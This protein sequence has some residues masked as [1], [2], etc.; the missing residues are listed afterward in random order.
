MTID[1]SAGRFGSVGLTAQDVQGIRQATDRDHIGSIFSRVWDK[2]ADWFCSTNRTEAKKC[3]FDLHSQTTTHQQKVDSFLS[4]KDM[5]GANYQNRFQIEE[6]DEGVRY[7]LDLS[8][9][10]CPGFSL[11]FR[12][13]PVN[14][15]TLRQEL[16]RSDYWSHNGVGP[17]RD[18]VKADICRASYTVSGTPLPDGTPDERMKHFDDALTAIG[19]TPSQ[20]EAI[21]EVCNQAVLG[22]FMEASD[23]PAI[24]PGGQN[25]RYDVRMV[26]GEVHVRAVCIKDIDMVEPGRQVD[27][28][29]RQGKLNMILSDGDHPFYK[30]QEM[31]LDLRIMDGDPRAMIDIAGVRHLA[32][33]DVDTVQVQ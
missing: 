15:E 17:A 20:R 5:A 3:M 12:K 9:E 14:Q 27:L 33:R 24:V 30:S 13:L 4:L 6:N 29:Q 8:D 32:S 28:E 18:Q 2:V 21:M 11:S 19:A 31:R 16:N 23:P 25:V 26:E 1:V 10:Q 22:T 7:N